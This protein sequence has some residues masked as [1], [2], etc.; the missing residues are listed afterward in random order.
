MLVRFPLEGNYP[1]KLEVIFCVRGGNQPIAIKY[2]PGWTG[3][4]DGPQRL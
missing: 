2:L 4:A 1:P 3:L